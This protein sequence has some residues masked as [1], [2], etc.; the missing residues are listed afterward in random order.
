MFLGFDEQKRP[1]I[2]PGIYEKYTAKLLRFH[3]PTPNF[4]FFKHRE[5]KKIFIPEQVGIYEIFE[6]F[7]VEFSKITKKVK[8][9]FLYLCG[10]QNQNEKW[11]QIIFGNIEQN[12]DVE[13][14]FVNHL[15]EGFARKF[16]FGESN[17]SLHVEGILEENDADEDDQNSLVTHDSF[18]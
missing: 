14:L 2:S 3:I 6:Q 5:W 13:L 10:K 7:D 1:P 4:Q 8:E 17:E 11:N 18:D 12:I 15:H 16:V 9:D